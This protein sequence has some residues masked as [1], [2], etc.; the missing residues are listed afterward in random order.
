MTRPVPDDDSRS[1]DR[2]PKKFPL[3][4]LGLALAF[5]LLLVALD[6]LRRPDRQYSV[7]V[8][9]GMVRSYQV[10][11]RPMTRQISHC[12]YRP[13][14][15]RYSIEAVE[16]HGIRR[17]LWLTTKRLLRCQSHIEAGTVDEVPRT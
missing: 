8:Y 4:R 1:D 2:P 9:V 6:S 14:C 16:K 7:I 17:G 13:T 12:P 10:M 5:C 11:G 15:S 3:G